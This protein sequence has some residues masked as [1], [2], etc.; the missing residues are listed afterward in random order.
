MQAARG[1][2]L[3]ESDDTSSPESR[4][5]A[6]RHI[7]LFVT[8]AV[9]AYLLDVV[10]KVVAVELLT[11]RGPV[12]VVDGILQLRLTGNPGAAF[13]LGTNYTVLLSLVQLTVACAVVWL[14]RRIGSRLW[15]LSLGL[16]LGGAVG[17]LTDRL[18]RDPGPL[19]GHVVDFLELPNWP[20]FNVAD[21]AIVTAAV[22]I[23]L[24]SMR[25]IRLDGSRAHP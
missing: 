7:R 3:N 22:L 20:V 18:L 2:S 12:D 25:G 11:G 8:V 9:T 5:S 10:S 14:S 1:T 4:M 6:Q 23:V 19:R 16:L 17:N 15:A 24:Q 13:S 21:C